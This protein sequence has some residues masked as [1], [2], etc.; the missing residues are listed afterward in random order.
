ML[1]RN[2]RWLFI[3]LQM[4]RNGRILHERILIFRQLSTLVENNIDQI[5]IA[6]INFYFFAVKLNCNYYN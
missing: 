4:K 5:M 3:K 6:I 1:N 2:S